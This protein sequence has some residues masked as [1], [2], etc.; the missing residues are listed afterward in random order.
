MLF[1]RF[2]IKHNIVEF[3]WKI[4]K[5]FH[6]NTKVHKIY[7]KKV[8]FSQIRLPHEIPKC[9]RWFFCNFL[10]PYEIPIGFF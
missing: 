10:K 7:I 9:F 6:E 8:P 2:K 3:F 5:P 1:F 4:I